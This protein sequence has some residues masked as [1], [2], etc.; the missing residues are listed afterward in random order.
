MRYSRVTEVYPVKKH[1]L[2]IVANRMSFIFILV[3]G[4]FVLGACS[5]GGSGNSTTFIPPN[6][7]GGNTTVWNFSELQTASYV[8]KLISRDGYLYWTEGSKNPVN[9]I[10][11]DG[12]TTAPLANH[13][14][15]IGDYAISGGYIY[16]FDINGTHIRRMTNDGRETIELASEGGIISALYL[17]DANVYWVESVPGQA[18]GQT[19]QHINTLPTTTGTLVTLSSTTYSVSYFKGDT[20]ALYWVENRGLHKFMKDGSEHVV[21]HEGLNLTAAP[22]IA[23]GEM[24]L[25]LSGPWVDGDWTGVLARMS[26]ADGALV[27]MYTYTYDYDDGNVIREIAADSSNVYWI[28][29]RDV[30]SI[31]LS[32]GT[33]TMLARGSKIPY[34][35]SVMMNRGLALS[36]DTVYWSDLTQ[37]DMM[38]ASQRGNL[39]SVPKTGGAISILREKNYDVTLIKEQKEGITWVAPTGT[40]NRYSPADGATMTALTLLTGSMEY[41]DIAVDDEN[42]YITDGSVIKKVTLAGGKLDI[43]FGGN[44]GEPITRVASDG[45]NLFWISAKIPNSLYWKLQKMTLTD[46]AISTVATDIADGSGKFI[47]GYYYCVDDILNTQN[48]WRISLDTGAASLIAQYA[49]WITDWTSDGV[50]LY[51]A[52]NDD[53]KIYSVPVSGGQVTIF[54]GTNINDRT[55]LA[56]DGQYLYAANQTGIQKISTNG[57][58]V[59]IIGGVDIMTSAMAMI[60]DSGSIFWSVNDPDVMHGGDGYIYEATPK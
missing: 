1:G 31:P 52:N 41:R 4:I 43:I 16:W 18:A 29:L 2:G 9:R 46:G 47:G 56:T 22:S 3:A 39:K 54:Q 59:E 50:K 49:G 14:S 26:L 36:G 58:S 15:G 33:V 21:L 27:S 17:D 35:P 5:S 12:G 30:K 40:I 34:W 20:E 51:F 10:Q 28:D 53:G 38:A 37:D 44:F 11:I 45:T 6:P 48:I 42:V 55:R 32:G 60:V 57:G 23:N 7:G 8:L 24:Y 25:G 13:T 19:L